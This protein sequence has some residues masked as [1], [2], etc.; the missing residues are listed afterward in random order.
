MR[1]TQ[2]Q[3]TNGTYS[4]SQEDPTKTNQ[5]SHL[6]H[7]SAPLGCLG[8]VCMPVPIGSRRGLFRLHFVLSMILNILKWVHGFLYIF[9]LA[10][11][12]QNL[13]LG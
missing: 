5:I 6:I 1:V 11:L 9:F 8:I 3:K 7:A 2:T 12:K 13:H 4:P 10:L